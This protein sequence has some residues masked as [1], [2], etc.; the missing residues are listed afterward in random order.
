MTGKGCFG[1][2]RYIVDFT[3]KEVCI[4]LKMQISFCFKGND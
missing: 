3:K 2:I 1:I 4:L